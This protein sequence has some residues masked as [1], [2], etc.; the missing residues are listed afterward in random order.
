[1]WTIEDAHI[2]MDPQWSTE[3]ISVKLRPSSPSLFV[4][5]QPES[6]EGK[7]DMEEQRRDRQKK[8]E[9]REEIMN[10]MCV[11]ESHRAKTASQIH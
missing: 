7:T 1:M 4:S 3:T 11:L 8:E 6:W 5:Y 2:N 10:S 9:K